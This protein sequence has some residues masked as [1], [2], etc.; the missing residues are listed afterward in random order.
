MKTKI[1]PTS[2]SKNKRGKSYSKEYLALAV[3]VLLLGEGGLFARTQPA[4]WQQAATLFDLS[5]SL[6][7]TA[8]EIQIFFSP[9]AMVVDGVNEFYQQAATAAIPLLDMS[10]ADNEAGEVI[11]AV[12]T[13]YDQ[14]STQMA[15]LLDFSSAAGDIGSV[16][17]IS[18]Q[19]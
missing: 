13:F 4:D 5:S 19:R 8:A 9:M 3:L 2:K 14:A 7:Q 15:Q 10:Q 1:K 17:G 12:S 18:I 11:M 6:G 16:A